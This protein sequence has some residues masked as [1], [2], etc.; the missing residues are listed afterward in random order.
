MKSLPPLSLPVIHLF[1]YR[2]KSFII[3]TVVILVCFL[4]F[5]AI[6]PS[7]VENVFI[8]KQTSENMQQKITLLSQNYSFLSGLSDSAVDAD[9]VISSLALPP[10]KDFQA[11]LQEISDTGTKT[12]VT[13]DDYG[14]EIG[15]FG[16]NIGS[17]T[18][19]VNL[20][21]HGSSTQNVVSFISSIQKAFP[22][23]EVTTSTLSGGDAGISV[24]FYFKEFPLI[25]DSNIVL[26]KMTKN[27]E[28]VLK[29]LAS[30]R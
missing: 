24:I 13:I 9:F 14:L 4:L 30:W 5:I 28:D 18:L 8:A 10:E 27:Q 23:A 2:Y 19:T 22:L 11:V 6:I 21:I 26:K 16:K 17:P 20:S 3:P 1:Y 29:T 15:D 7:Q 25:K 12:G